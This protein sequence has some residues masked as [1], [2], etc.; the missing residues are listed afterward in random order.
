MEK[1]LTCQYYDRRNATPADG[2]GPMW[3]QCRRT[4]PRLHPVNAKSYMIE[5]VWPHVRDDDWCG[6][7]K[8]AARTVPSRISEP[9]TTPAHVTPP[10]VATL[11]PLPGPVAAAPT[12]V[13]AP[14]AAYELGRRGGAD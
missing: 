9:L 11:S 3:G 7:W 13:G 12:S 4:A 14:L 1:C 5:G 8:G 2:K 10:R 6:E